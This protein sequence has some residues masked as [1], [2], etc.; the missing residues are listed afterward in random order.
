MRK[1]LDCYNLMLLQGYFAFFFDY[2][3]H[4]LS[5]V[6]ASIPRKITGK[7]KGKLIKS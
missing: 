2:Y 3:G 4:I 1:K 7:T 5:T 6:R